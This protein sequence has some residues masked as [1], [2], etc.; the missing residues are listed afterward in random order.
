MAALPQPLADLAL[1]VLAAPMAGGPGTPELVIAAGRAG[2]FGFLAGGYKTPQ[3]LAEQMQ[4]V[5][6]AGVEFGVN[7]FAPNAVTIDLGDYRRYA[8]AIRADLELHGT[9][10]PAAPIEDDDGWHEKVELLLADPPA[11]VSFTF[12]IPPPEAIAALRDAGSVTV[13]TVTTADEADAAAAAGVDALAVQAPGAGGHSGTFDPRRPIIARALADVVAEV[14]A[15]TSLPLLAAGG[16]ASAVDVRAALEA[17]A[18]R[19]LVGTALMLADEAGTTATH[20]AALVAAERET[21]LT[22]AFTG[23]PARGLRNEF[24]DRHEAEAPIGYPALHH[25]TSG[26]RRAA[27]AAGDAER[28]HLWAGTGYGAATAEPAAAILGRL[29]ERV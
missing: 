9:N 14:A 23:R 12:G 11:V 20:R 21:T 26:M 10:A 27:A 13:Q 8:E 3:A 2:S 24:I 4:A 7:L 29:A 6:A 16:I 28:V 17:G 18:A 1:P 15:R 25:L 19:V 22:R 5:R